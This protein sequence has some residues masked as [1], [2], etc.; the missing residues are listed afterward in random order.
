MKELVYSIES[1]PEL[2]PPGDIR[3][4]VMARITK[5]PVPVSIRTMLR[6]WLPKLGYA[7]L[8]GLGL[9]I[10]C[11]WGVKWIYQTYIQ[12]QYDPIDLLTKSIVSLSSCIGKVTQWLVGFWISGSA[13]LQ[14]NLSTITTMLMIETVILIAGI[15]YWYIRKQKSTHFIFA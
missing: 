14:S 11:F 1:L 8:T 13:M 10:V 4:W 5:E 6:N 3:Q 2:E 15:T 7:Y 9:L 12:S